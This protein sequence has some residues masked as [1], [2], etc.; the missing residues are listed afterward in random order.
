[1]STE[2][3]RPRTASQQARRRALLAAA[4]QL[5]AER[6]FEQ[7]QV[8]EVAEA[9]G[10]AL[11]TLYRYFPSKELLYAHAL[12]DWSEGFASRASTAP[13]STDADRLRRALHRAVRAYER[14]PTYFRMINLLE[15]CPD[16]DVRAAFA[17]FS[18]QFFGELRRALVDADPAD[19]ETIVFVAASVLDSGLRGWVNGMASLA[20]VRRRLD[21]TVALVLPDAG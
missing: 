3:V 21:A 11:G 20:E 7:I 19:A 17:S 6:E 16:D 5:L 10:V 13:G 14:A 15:V 2:L 9:A 1:M 12:L 8:R 4:Q 18:E